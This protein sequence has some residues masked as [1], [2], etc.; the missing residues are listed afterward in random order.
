MMA[1]MQELQIKS[2]YKNIMMKTLN[3]VTINGKISNV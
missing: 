3:Q 2:S 1:V